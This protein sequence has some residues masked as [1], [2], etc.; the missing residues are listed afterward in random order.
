VPPTLLRPTEW[1]HHVDAGSAV[2]VVALQDR[3]LRRLRTA[4][5]QWETTTK[6]RAK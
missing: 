4:V 5:E 2:P 6:P 1:D 3:F